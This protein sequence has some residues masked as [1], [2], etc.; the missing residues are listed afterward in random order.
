MPYTSTHGKTHVT[1]RNWPCVEYC[2]I[3]DHN[4]LTLFNLIDLHLLN[5]IKKYF[6]LLWTGCQLGDLNSRLWASLWLQSWHLR[7]LA[8]LLKVCQKIAVLTFYLLPYLHTIFF[9]SWISTLSS[10]VYY[11][12]NSFWH[13]NQPMASG[14]PFNFF[15]LFTKS[16]SQYLRDLTTFLSRTQYSLGFLTDFFHFRHI[17]DTFQTHFRHISDT[18][19]TKIRIKYVSNQHASL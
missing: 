2:S 15:N 8:P 10:Q 18:W 19:I 3:T 14:C 4:K 12:P 17:S 13:I 1:N 6:L 5:K 7:G 9:C 16:Y 11:V